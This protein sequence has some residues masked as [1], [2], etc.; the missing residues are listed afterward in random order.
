MIDSDC[1]DKSFCPSISSGFCIYA[2]VFM[3]IVYAILVNLV[4]LK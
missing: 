1:V 4:C 3:R 2:S